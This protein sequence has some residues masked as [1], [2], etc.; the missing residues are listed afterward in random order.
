[1]TESLHNPMYGM[2]EMHVLP[3][4][5]LM[6]HQEDSTCWCGP[7]DEVVMRADGSNGYLY[8]HHSLDGREIAYSDN[9]DNYKGV[10]EDAQDFRAS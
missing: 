6:K 1:M 5:D 9:T 8:T 7:Q 3:V 4:N 10:D 2:N